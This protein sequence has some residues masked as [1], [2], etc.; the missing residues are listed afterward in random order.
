MD[1]KK[2]LSKAL[3]ELQQVDEKLSAVSGTISQKM[4]RAIEAQADVWMPASISIADLVRIEDDTNGSYGVR[5]GAVGELIEYLGI[6]RDGAVADYLQAEKSSAEVDVLKA[7]RDKLVKRIEAALT[8]AEAEGVKV[9]VTIPKD[10]T[11]RSGGGGSRGGTKVSTS[12][13]NFWRIVPGKT[14][15]Y[16][17]RHNTL[18]GVA[19]YHTKGL[20]ENGAKVEDNKSK[21]SAANLEKFLV[22]QGIDILAG[23]WECKLPNGTTIGADKV[24]R[25]EADSTPD[26]GSDDE[27]DTVKEGVEA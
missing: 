19:F 1:I 27:D 13:L 17:G 3:E 21:M 16:M 18:G 10:P 7:Q 6:L 26:A 5:V 23:G 20:D 9:D 11:K 2:V 8:L 14:K 12:D 25:P 4:A 24:V 22:A 15:E